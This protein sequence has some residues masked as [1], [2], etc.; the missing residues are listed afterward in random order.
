MRTEPRVEDWV[1]RTLDAGEGEIAV[2]EGYIRPWVEATENRNPLYW[3]PRSAEEVTG[4]PIAPP[5]M[6][7]VWMR[8]LAWRPDRDETRMPLALHFELKKAFDLPEGVVAENEVTFHE[9]LRPGDRV[10]VTESV[11]EIGEE[12]KTKLGTGRKWI[13]DVTYTNQRGELVGVETY[14]MFGYRR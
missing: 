5:S 7:S 14:R 1:G 3:D 6:L 9:P 12:R 10:R 4:G 8:P 11:R 2:E 13:I